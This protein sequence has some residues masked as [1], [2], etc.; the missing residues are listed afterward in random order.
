M[1]C[2]GR[3]R[4]DIRKKGLLR[5]SGEPSEQTAQGGGGTTIPRGVE[6][7]WR[8]GTEGHD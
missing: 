5:K 3:F 4:L 6:E 2:M 8:C 1:L 7:P